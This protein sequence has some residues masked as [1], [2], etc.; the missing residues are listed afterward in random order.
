MF[1]RTFS[2]EYVHFLTYTVASSCV[3]ASPLAAMTIV[4][5]LWLGKPLGN[6]LDIVMAPQPLGPSGPM[7]QNLL[8]TTRTQD[9]QI[10]T[11][12][13]TEAEHARSAIFFDFHANIITLE[14]L[15]GSENSGQRPTH[16]SASLP[17]YIA[18]QIPCQQSSY[19]KK[20][21]NA[22]TLCP[23]TWMMVSLSPLIVHFA[24]PIPKIVLESKS[25]EDREIGRRVRLCGYLWPQ[26]SMTSSLNEIVKTSSSSLHLTPVNKSSAFWTART[27][28]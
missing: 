18:K 7:A 23:C 13:T 21:P 14:C 4:K 26:N 11:F 10:H 28:R 19:S 9:A 12:H 22:K 8:T 2:Q 17:Q 24:M 15:F 25:T 3:C 16:L 1:S 6:Y 27:V 20:E 5:R